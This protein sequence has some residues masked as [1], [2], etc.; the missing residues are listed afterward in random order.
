MFEGNRKLGFVHKNFILDCHRANVGPMSSYRLFKEVVGTYNDVG[1]TGNDYRNFYRDLSVYIFGCDAQMMLNTMFMWKESSD[2]F[3]FTYSV[4]KDDNLKSIF[5]ADL[6][7]RRN[8]A[9]FGDVVLFDCTYKKNSYEMIFAPFTGKDNHG[10]CVMFSASLL[11]GENHESYEWVFEK[12]KECMGGSPRTMIRDQD[13]AMKIAIDRVLPT[14]RHHLCMWHIMLRVPDRSPSRLK[15]D[16]AFKKRLNDIVWTNMIEHQEFEEKWKSVMVDFDLTE[17]SWFR[18]LFEIRQYWIPAYFRDYAISGLCRTT[19]ISESM[20]SFFSI[21]LNL[22]SNLVEFLM[23]FDSAM[24]A[25]RNS[26]ELQNN[27]DHLT[28]P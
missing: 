2:A 27:H 15:H 3:F 16:D 10:K 12:F 13:P 8:Y 11:S 7:S 9:V 5:W 20:N 24:D 4:D 23:H 1:R 17:H 28:I 21:Y 26:N 19:S 25:Q 22:G 14:T 18:S 6:I